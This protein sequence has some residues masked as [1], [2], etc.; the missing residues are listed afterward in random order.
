MIP[1]I[2]H[3]CWFGRGEKPALAQMCISACKKYLSDYELKEWNEDNFDINS[4]QYV[5]EAYE[6]KKWAFVSD[7]VRLYALYNEGGVYLDT[8]CELLGRIDSFLTNP[9]FS[10]YESKEA[11]LTAIMGAEKGN[12]WIKLLLDYYENRSFYNQDGSLD[13]TT[14]VIIISNLTKEQYGCKYDG[15]QINIPGK[16]TIYP[17]DYFCPKSCITGELNL[18]E[19]SVAIHHFNASWIGDYTVNL[20]NKKFSFVKKYGRELGEE[21]YKRW[22]RRNKIYIYFRLYGVKG[23]VK[24]AIKKFDRIFKGASKQ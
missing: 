1:K 5:K 10:G 15:K 16:F 23:V 24:S 7:Y 17:V 12:E 22:Y 11:I 21:K 14:N 2:I 4:N 3:Y 19:N 8:D 13:I 20:R 18:T 6:N 9:A